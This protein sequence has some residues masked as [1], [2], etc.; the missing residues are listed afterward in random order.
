M[1]EDPR[2]RGREAD[3]LRLGLDLGLTLI[4]TAEMYGEGEAETIVGEAVAGRRDAV[5]LVSKVYPH[6]AGRRA[7]AEACER[8]LRRLGTDRIDLY[9]LHWPGTVPL[10]ETLEA[11]SALKRAGKILD[12]GLSN[13]DREGME[14][15][16]SLPGG[17]AVA[18][19]QVLYNL[20]RRGIE[21]D[22]LP[23]CRA[24]GIPVMA[25]SPLEQGRLLRRQAL[26]GVAMRRGMTPAQAA[27]AWLLAQSGVC[28]IPKAADPD[29]VREARAAL[30]LTLTPEDMADLDR[31]FPAP[32][33]P[34][35]L[36]ML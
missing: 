5:T 15:A 4:D 34:G 30:D 25:Y 21:R 31:A 7:A 18:V 26:R 10:E 6:H 16:V 32:S 27:L 14:G 8:S 11:F 12:H 33:R 3:A 22:L 36:E 9:L 28:V 2:A 24:R 35:P 20:A 17:E 13:F 1:G 29:H 19:D 23:W